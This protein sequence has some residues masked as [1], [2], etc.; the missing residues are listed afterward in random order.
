MHCYMDFASIT[1]H[2]TTEGAKLAAAMLNKFGFEFPLIIGEEVTTKDWHMNA[3]PVKE[4]ISWELSPFETIKAAHIQGAVIQWNHPGYPRSEWGDAHIDG[5]LKGT[6]LDAWEHIPVK[7]EEWK[8]AGI[9]PVITGTTDTHSG[10]FS[11]PE[12]T[13]IFAP[14][15]TGYDVAEAVR[16]GRVVTVHAAG[17][18]DIFY[19]SD[20]MI[21]V[22]CHLLKNGDKLKI[23]KAERLKK[24]LRNAD[25]AGLIKASPP[26]QVNVESFL[27]D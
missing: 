22:A 2:N 25:I 24:A 14:T 5:A 15:A 13:L 20:D 1:D 17:G 3:Y 19:G 26:K 27:S 18:P 16:W 6:G 12:R 7:Y 11:S 23:L 21:S 4:L 9:L 10:T 8:L